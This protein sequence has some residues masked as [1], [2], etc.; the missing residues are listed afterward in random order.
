MP[1]LPSRLHR[2]HGCNK[3]NTTGVFL[4]FPVSNGLW[5]SGVCW[6]ICFPVD[7]ATIYWTHLDDLHF[8]GAKRCKSLDFSLIFPHKSSKSPEFPPENL[9]SLPSLRCSARKFDPQKV[10]EE[11]QPRFGWWRS[12][13]TPSR[14]EG[15][16]HRVLAVGELR[17]QYFRC[18][19]P[20]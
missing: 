14:T 13:P 11:A 12:S 5:S 3:T 19:S 15:F 16:F 7:E 1:T 9:P 6:G 18:I 2:I 10:A 20:T 17:W 8:F 4:S